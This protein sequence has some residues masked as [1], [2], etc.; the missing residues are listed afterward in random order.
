MPVADLLTGLHD[1]FG[2]Q[3]N[4]A[5]LAPDASAHHYAGNAEN[6]VFAFRLGPIGVVS[7]GIYSLDRSLFRFV[8][9][10]ATERRLVRPGTTATLDRHGNATTAS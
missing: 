10:G 6:P 2:G 4:L 3:A 1:R 9:P 8:A 7:T 5:T